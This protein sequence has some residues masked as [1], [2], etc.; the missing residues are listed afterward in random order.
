MFFQRS[1]FGGSA[2]HFNE[3]RNQYY[4]H[5]F[6]KEQP[7]LNLRNHLVVL[8]LQKVLRFWLDLGVAGFR[9]DAVPHFFEDERFLDEDLVPDKDPDTYESVTRKYTY[10][11]QPEINDLLKKFRDVLD[12]YSAKDGIQRLMMTEAYV[13]DDE[14]MEYYGEIDENTQI[15]SVSQIPVNFGLVSSKFSSAEKV[16]LEVRKLGIG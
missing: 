2:W 13:S 10:N 11:L 8:E 16:S 6:Y 3:T 15:G 7:D 14:L 4:L 1:V 12:E 9:I 5:Q